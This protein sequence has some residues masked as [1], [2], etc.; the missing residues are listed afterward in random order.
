MTLVER[1]CAP[2]EL[3]LTSDRKKCQNTCQ[4]RKCCWDTNERFR[5]DQAQKE[6][7]QEFASCL[8]LNAVATLDLQ[9]PQTVGKDGGV[10]ALSGPP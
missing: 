5:C 9:Q 1:L 6:W 8:N 3:S 10:S 2:D 4:K 7:C